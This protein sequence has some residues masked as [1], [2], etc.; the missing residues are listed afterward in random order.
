MSPALAGGFLP[1]EPPEIELVF[2]P[3]VSYEESMCTRLGV[4]VSKSFHGRLGPHATGLPPSP[5]SASTPLR[6]PCTR[7][8]LCHSPRAEGPMPELLAFPPSLLLLPGLA[9]Q[10]RF[11]GL[12]VLDGTVNFTQECGRNDSCYFQS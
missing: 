12:L 4:W 11:P 10:L 1:P 7:S 9:P 8:L 3:L 2:L 6:L 5:T